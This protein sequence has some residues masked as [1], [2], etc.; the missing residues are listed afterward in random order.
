MMT[1]VVSSFRIKPPRRCS[2]TQASHL[3]ESNA[4][5]IFQ[6]FSP[7]ALLAR[8]QQAR[9]SDARM[10]RSPGAHSPL[11]RRTSSHNSPALAGLLHTRAG[12]LSN[13]AGSSR[14]KD[15]HSRSSRT[16]KR[17]LSPTATACQESRRELSGAAPMVSPNRVANAP[18]LAFASP[19]HGMRSHGT[20]ARHSSCADASQSRRESSVRPQRSGGRATKA[21]VR[22]FAH[23]LAKADSL[24]PSE[25]ATR[26]RPRPDT[27]IR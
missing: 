24:A 2:P 11:C 12:L 26:T 27:P 9:A 23:S 3:D 10:K 15:S 1:T 5:R 20:Q 18:A 22:I 19:C 4:R 25:M 6:G 17:Q 8:N 14:G 13:W 7:A 21:P 16:T